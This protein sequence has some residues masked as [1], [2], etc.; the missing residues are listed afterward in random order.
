MAGFLIYIRCY[1]KVRRTEIIVENYSDHHT[2]NP[3]GMIL[4]YH[5]FWVLVFSVFCVL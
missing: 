2:L 1:A 3:E 5:P 4:S